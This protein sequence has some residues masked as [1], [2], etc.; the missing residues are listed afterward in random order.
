MW[1][2]TPRWSLPLRRRR[3]RRR[4]QRRRRRRR[5]CRRR[6]RRRRDHTRH[7]RCQPPRRGRAW[8]APPQAQRLGRL[9]QLQP[10]PRRRRLRGR[11]RA[12]RH[13]GDPRPTATCAAACWYGRCATNIVLSFCL[14]EAACAPQV[15]IQLVRHCTN[16]QVPPGLALRRL[17]PQWPHPTP[18]E[19]FA[20]SCT[21]AVQADGAELRRRSCQR[22]VRCSDK[23]AAKMRIGSHPPAP[24]WPLRHFG[25]ALVSAHDTRPLTR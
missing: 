16:C 21:C 25:H 1:L 3:C 18:Q 15:D 17:P 24:P 6:R 5:Q 7:R 23:Q 22:T 20:S 11:R 9:L 4:R 12:A 13:A 19:P 14:S 2:T 10:R 8:E